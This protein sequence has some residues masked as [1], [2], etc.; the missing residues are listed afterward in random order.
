MNARQVETLARLV[1]YAAPIPMY[2]DEPAPELH[3][4]LEVAVGD[5]GNTYEAKLVTYEM[6]GFYRFPDRFYLRSDGGM[7]VMD[8]ETETPVEIVGVAPTVGEQEIASV[9]W[10]PRVPGWELTID[11]RTVTV[12]EVRPDGMNW[13]E[14]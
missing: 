10:K 14:A 3:V 13:I 7:Y 2:P 5:D 11:R 6:T 1:R 12:T 9:R 4:L 8:R